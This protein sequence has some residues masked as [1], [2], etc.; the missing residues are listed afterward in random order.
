MHNASISNMSKMTRFPRGLAAFAFAAMTVTLVPGHGL[1]QPAATPTFTAEQAERGHAIYSHS[2]VDCHGT[3]LDNGE[4]GGPVL[5]GGFFRQ[6]W[7]ATGVGALYSFTKG[8]MPPDRPGQLTEQNYA[9]VIA[10]ILSNNGV[11]PGDKELPTDL[12]ALQN[13]GIKP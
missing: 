13:M 9:D 2:C 4:F 8:L 6:K 1:A 5:K 11:A 12:N 10:F 7:S 3:T